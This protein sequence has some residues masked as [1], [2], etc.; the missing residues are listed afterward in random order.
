MSKKIN[1]IKAKRADVINKMT[2]LSELATTEERAFTLEEQTSFDDYDEKVK[3]LTKALENEQRMEELK[4]MSLS[5]AAGGSVGEGEEKET[6][7]I[8][9]RYSFLK[10]VRSQIPALS[11]PF[12]G[13]EKEMHQE[14][15]REAR[16][17]KIKT[18]FQGFGV[19]TMIARGSESRDMTVGTTTA[20]GHTVQTDLGELI[21]FLDPRLFVQQLGAT[22]LDGLVGNLD[23]PR[24]NG[25]VTTAWEGENDTNAETDPTFEK[26]SLTPKRL[27]AYTDI[28]KQLLAQS[29]ISVE[30]WLRGRLSFAIARGKDVA[31]INGSGSSGQPLGILGTSGIGSVG[32]GT[33]GGAPTHDHMVD[34]ETAIATANA[35]MG[36]LAYLLTPG[37]VGKLKKTKTDT[38]SGIFVLPSGATDLNG[39]NFLKSTLVPSDL[40]KGSGTALHAAIFG[41]WSELLIAN[42]AG[43]DVVVNPYTKA[44]EALVELVVNSWTDIAVRHAASFAAIVDADIS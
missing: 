34:L 14:A 6:K 27:G 26:I 2:A 5:T 33:N 22:V 36:N 39:Y 40:T 19:P 13:V 31:A 30:N 3:S 37:L 25:D 11:I 4:K 1:E 32:I 8:K 28:S 38:G 16:A 10:A 17:A 7:K 43:Y 12:D 41:N 42:W 20:G 21:P 15:E 9:K 24:N 29:S 44:K 35:D 18:E 23:L